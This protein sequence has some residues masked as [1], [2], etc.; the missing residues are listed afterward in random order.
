MQMSKTYEIRDR[1]RRADAARLDAEACAKAGYEG[2]ARLNR[3]VAAFLDASMKP[4][5]DT[6]DSSR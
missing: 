3:E 6:E 1:K 4:A 5:D 2:F